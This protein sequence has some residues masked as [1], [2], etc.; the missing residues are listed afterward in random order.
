MNEKDW[1][2]LPDIPGEAGTNLITVSDDQM[3]LVAPQKACKHSSISNEFESWIH[4]PGEQIL[5]CIIAA[6]DRTSQIL[7]ISGSHNKILITIN[8]ST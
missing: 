4:Y 6:F 2:K 1:E 5:S 7:Y 8:F 3:M